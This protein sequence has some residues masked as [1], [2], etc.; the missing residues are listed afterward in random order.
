MV[1]LGIRHCRNG[2]EHNLTGRWD[3]YN[4]LTTRGPAC[5]QKLKTVIVEFFK[6]CL[7]APQLFLVSFLV[8]CNGVF[9]QQPAQTVCEMLLNQL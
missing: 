5:V 8:L 6:Y 7:L 3:A 4:N 1:R 9:L 2:V